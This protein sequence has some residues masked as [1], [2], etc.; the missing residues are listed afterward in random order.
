VLDEGHDERPTQGLA[1]PVHVLQRGVDANDI[2]NMTAICV[3]DAQQAA[4]S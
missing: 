3:I 4:S 1:K 2:V